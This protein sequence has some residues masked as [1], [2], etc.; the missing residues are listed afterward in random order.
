MLKAAHWNVAHHSD[1]L[2]DSAPSP[3]A[4]TSITTTCSAVLRSQISSQTQLSSCLLSNKLVKSSLVG[5]ERS[6]HMRPKIV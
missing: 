4:L 2:P 1:P 3:L 5:P 6:L